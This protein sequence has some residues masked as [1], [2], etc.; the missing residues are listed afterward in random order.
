MGYYDVLRQQV[1]LAGERVTIHY[2]NGLPAWNEV[3]SALLLLAEGVTIPSGARVLVLE[4]GSGALAVWAARRGAEVHCYDGSLLASRMTRQSL[5]SN[6]V[7]GHVYD[8][9]CPP[10]SA[11]GTFDLALLVIPKGRAYTRAL[12]GGTAR[13]LKP[14]ARL[15]LAGANAAGAKALVKDAG[16]ILGRSATVRT[17]AR[18]RLGMAVRLAAAPGAP[19]PEEAFHEFEADGLKLT[20]APGVFSWEALDDGTACLLATLDANLCGGQRVLDV[21]CGSGAIGF[22]AARNGAAAVDMIDA[23]WLAVE[24]ARL[25][26]RANGLDAVCRAWPADLYADVPDGTYDLILSNPPFHI[27][28]AVETAAAEALISGAHEHLVPGGRL[29]LVANVFLPYEPLLA[30]VF[31]AGRVRTVA[32]DARYRVLEAAR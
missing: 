5:A 26:I 4:S 6:G 12:L 24:C 32:E 16:A 25:G 14:G 30:A 28:Q 22:T 20:G 11:A 1:R 29:R 13:A 2:K 18:N 3:E 21:G 8:A 23:A 19:A 17:R 9:V 7:T 31:G 27:G 10:P 15:Y